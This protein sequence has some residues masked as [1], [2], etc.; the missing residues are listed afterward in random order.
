[1]TRGVGMKVTIEV[2]DVC[3]DPDRKVEVWRV[4]SP[5]ARL[6]RLVLCE[7]HAKPLHVLPDSQ[8]PTG[9]SRSR[10]PVLDRKDVK[11]R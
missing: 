4:A 3:H 1:M 9:R 10:K 2:C 6:R 11:G 5:G 8:A 7:E